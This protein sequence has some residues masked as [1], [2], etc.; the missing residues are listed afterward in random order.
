MNL[1][2]RE[3]I[4][5]EVITFAKTDGKFGALSNMAPGHNL[6]V[7]EINIRSSEILYQ[8]CRFPLFPQIQQEIIDVKSPMDAKKISRHYISYSRQDWDSVKFKVMKWCL[9]VKLIQ[10]FSSFS[11]LLI[12]TGDKAIVEYSAKDSLWGANPKS[13]DTLVGVNALGRLLMELREKIKVGNLTPNTVIAP[14]NI[15]AFSLFDKRITDVYNQ[16]YFIRDLD[17]IYA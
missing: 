11:E 13:Q 2:A 1:S 10:N 14:V 5:R 7:N 4:T 9:E 15:P 16:E 3:Y 12:S 6:F 8:A 17:E